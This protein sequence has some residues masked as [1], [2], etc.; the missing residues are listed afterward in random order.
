MEMGAAF[1]CQMAALDTSETLQNSTAY[2][3]SWLKPLQNNPKWVL[4]ASKQAKD[5]V[6]FVLTG[7][8]PEGR[9]RAAASATA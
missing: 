1:L 6:E 7:R 5:A 9:A 4:Q 2:I 8:L 3:G